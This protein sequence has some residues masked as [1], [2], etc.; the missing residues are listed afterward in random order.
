MH[1]QH[2]E[3]ENLRKENEQLKLDNAALAKKSVNDKPEEEGFDVSR[4]SDPEDN[5][6]ETEIPF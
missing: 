1:Y 5:F 6:I 2:V 4:M 3:L